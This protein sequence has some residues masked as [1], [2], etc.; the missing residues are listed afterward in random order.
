LAHLR[1]GGLKPPLHRF[2]CGFSLIEV[3]AAVVI[4][5]IGM[6]AVLGIFAPV[7]KSV[8][9][10]S[11][12]EAASRAADAVRARL[13][14]LPFD[15][16]LALVQE[17][18]DVRRKDGDGA[19]NPNDGT[20]YPAVIFGKLSGDIG[21]YDPGEGRRA[22]YDSSVPTPVRVENA[23]KFFEIDLIRNETLTPKADDA[24]APMVAFTMR[25]RW[26]AFVAASSGA[27]VQVG[28]NPAG[29]GQVP[30][31]HSKKQ[32]LFFTGSILR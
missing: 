31:D 3:I 22:W 13:Q 9:T 27:A 6:V 32:V 30:Y 18:A 19:Y 26:P 21:I 7:T 17:G 1:K 25:I 12:A 29:G 4:F 16:A 20:R 2:A 23:D 8:A 11:D 15:Q 24:T 14:A 28:A 10:V 5:G